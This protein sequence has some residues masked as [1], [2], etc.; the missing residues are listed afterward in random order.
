MT[1]QSHY[2][3]IT[4]IIFPP[5][6]KEKIILK[7]STGEIHTT[8]S[9]ILTKGQIVVSWLLN[10]SLFVQLYSEVAARAFEQYIRSSNVLICI[11]QK[12]EIL[13]KNWSNF[14]IDLRPLKFSPKNLRPLI[15]LSE[16]LRPLKKHSGR[17]FP[18]NNVHPLDQTYQ[19]REAPYHDHQ[20]GQNQQIIQLYRR[21]MLGHRWQEPQP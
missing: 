12:I 15:F 17:V 14:K 2:D 19:Q 8:K 7:K 13:K 21:N 1:Q 5:N 10:G 16:N 18:I 9:A 11:F 6:C 3:I 4:F 20:R